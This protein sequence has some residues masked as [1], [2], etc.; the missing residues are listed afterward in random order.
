M[1]LVLA[2]VM[3]AVATLDIISD[4]VAMLK[5]VSGL[6]RLRKSRCHGHGQE[7]GERNRTKE[8][9]RNIVR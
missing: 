9:N 7:R 6:F 8:A 2:S 3:V 5:G 4:F 1:L